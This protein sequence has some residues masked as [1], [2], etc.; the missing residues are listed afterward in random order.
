MDIKNNLHPPIKTLKEAMD[1]KMNSTDKKILLCVSPNYSMFMLD[2]E[3]S[4]LRK[5]E[6][7]FTKDV[8]WRPAIP[9][10]ILYLAGTLRK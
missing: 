7:D 3:I 6:S 9:L 2:E 1:I 10:G 8:D 5:G 4:N